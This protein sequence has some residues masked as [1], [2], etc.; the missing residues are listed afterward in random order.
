MYIRRIRTFVVQPSGCVVPAGFSPLPAS[1]FPYPKDF[2][3]LHEL[4]SGQVCS[5][6][7]MF[8][9]QPS[10]CVASVGFSPLPDKSV[11]CRTSAAP[12][13]SMGLN[14]PFRAWIYLCMIP[15]TLPWAVIARAFGVLNSTLSKNARNRETEKQTI[16]TTETAI[17]P[18]KKIGQSLSYFK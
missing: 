9:V 7:C 14:R 5:G 4:I 8:V 18:A 11:G 16:I 3:L 10:G 2:I 1:P 12:T 17:R 13:R 15:R 6:T